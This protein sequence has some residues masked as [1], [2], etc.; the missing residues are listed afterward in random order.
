[1]YE[2]TARRALDLAL[3]DDWE[4]FARELV[5][6]RERFVELTKVLEPERDA[7]ELYATMRATL[8]ARVAAIAT[9]APPPVRATRI[10][11][12]VQHGFTITK[13]SFAELD[14][15]VIAIDERPYIVNID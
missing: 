9:T 2:L 1:M 7:D 15:T 14:I 13:V 5:V 10:V 6:S 8:Q 11:A 12:R 4:T 3:G